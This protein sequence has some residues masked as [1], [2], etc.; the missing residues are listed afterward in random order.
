MKEVFSIK[1]SKGVKVGH[2][3]RFEGGQEWEPVPF[4]IP[5]YVF[6][7]E[8]LGIEKI[9]SVLISMNGSVSG[10][11]NCQ[12]G[13]DGSSLRL[14]RVLKMFC[15]RGSIL[16]LTAT[17]SFPASQLHSPNELASEAIQVLSPSRIE[18]QSLP[19]LLCFL[20]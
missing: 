12:I 3:K 2:G 14:P 8:I 17:S 7:K 9:L 11:H 20:L 1:A 5:L 6:T 13:L 10:L 15:K 4:G 19:R 18:F 16:H